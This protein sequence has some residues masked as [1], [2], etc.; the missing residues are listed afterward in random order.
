MER[1]ENELDNNSVSIYLVIGL[2]LLFLGRLDMCAAILE[3]T[4]MITSKKL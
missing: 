4:N 3:A 2:S 1:P